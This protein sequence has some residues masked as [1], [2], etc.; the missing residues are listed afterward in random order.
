MCRITISRFHRDRGVFEA[1]RREVLPDVAARAQAE[2]R[3]AEA[4]SAGCAS[5][6]EAYTVR[7]LWDLEV[8]PGAPLNVLATDV[9][10][11]MIARAR[12]ACYAP[13]SLRELPPGLVERAFERRGR[14]ACLKPEHRAGVDFAAQDLRAAMPERAFDL[15]LCRYLAFT[16][17]AEPLQRR[18]LAALVERLRPG[19][20]LVI[21]TH[22]RLPETPELEAVS[23]QVFKRVPSP[24][25]GEGGARREAT[26]G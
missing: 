2:G 26:G 12:Q 3:A 10:P 24:L 11:A 14:E 15:I 18:V 25:A 16:Y 8:V 9:D 20:W 13:G 19:G 1:V 5:G 4:W 22:E 17:F 7:V 23:P 6:E 21:G